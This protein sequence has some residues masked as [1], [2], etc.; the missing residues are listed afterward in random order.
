M[1]LIIFLSYIL[2]LILITSHLFKKVAQ[3]NSY[4]R[5]ESK[6]MLTIDF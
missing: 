2:N 4:V 5:V 6:T 3:K 1:E